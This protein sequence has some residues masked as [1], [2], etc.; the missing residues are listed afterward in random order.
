[1][2][3]ISLESISDR[4]DLFA[5]FQAAMS[6]AE[7]N[8]H[9][10]LHYEKEQNLP[11]SYLIEFHPKHHET[12]GN[13]SSSSLIA[14]LEKLKKSCS[15]LQIKQTKDESLTYVLHQEEK[16]HYA[17]FIIDSLDS[18]FLV[19][20]TLSNASVTDKFI[21]DRLTP[22]CAEFD[23]FWFPSTLLQNIGKSEK[24]IGW[25][26]AFDKL[27]IKEEE[28]EQQ[29]SF[30]YKKH[31]DIDPKVNIKIQAQNA[32]EKYDKL[33]TTN[34]IQHIPLS[35]ITA[36]RY[37]ET[38]LSRSTARIKYNGK[39]TG[40]GQSFST[41]LN[42]INNT[43][44]NY[45]TII[46]KLE[47]E[48]W[49]GMEPLENGKDPVSLK[50]YGKPFC[51]KFSSEIDGLKNLI[52]RMFNCTYPFRLMGEAQ[53]ISENYFC[54]DAVDL[55]INQ[56]L[57]FEIS[58]K[59]MRIYLYEGTCGN[60]IVRILRTLQNYVDSTISHPPLTYETY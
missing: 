16:S 36:Q 35:S 42:I 34:I 47:R 46:K 23:Q 51:I 37:N 2:K 22:Y 7:D 27:Y 55:H 49:I 5:T 45:A 44:D 1:M 11:K 10:L 9:T 20:H 24:V 54:V 33:K 53:E 40:K 39:I 30:E 52:K 31:K 25:E 28:D 14:S 15:L 8:L 57:K 26:A 58:S 59:I 21:F 56:P 12:C 3:Q 13:G 60:S 32:L 4:N 48:Y 18:R 43:M 19:F 6:N 29:T 17:E 41:Y 38:D 50:I